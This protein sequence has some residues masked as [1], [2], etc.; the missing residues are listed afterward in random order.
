VES[1]FDLW[2]AVTVMAKLKTYKTTI[3]RAKAALGPTR[4]VAAKARAAKQKAAHEVLS[5]P[6]SACGAERNNPCKLASG[7]RRTDPQPER[8]WAASDKRG[9]QRSEK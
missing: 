8:R 5:V 7:K 2:E 6:C 4:S 1:G 9:K 3:A